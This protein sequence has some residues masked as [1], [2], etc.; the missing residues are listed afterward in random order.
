MLKKNNNNGNCFQKSS[1]K[2]KI[3]SIFYERLCY[4]GLAV[5]I[6]VCR[7]HQS[8]DW[9]DEKEEKNSCDH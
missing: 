9:S 2:N 6:C 8:H 4:A 5:H 3:A 7:S 1:D